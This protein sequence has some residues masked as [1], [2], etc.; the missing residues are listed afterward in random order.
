MYRTKYAKVEE[1]Y[2]ANINGKIEAVKTKRHIYQGNR[3]SISK[4]PSV[5][6]YPKINQ[7]VKGTGVRLQ[8]D[9]DQ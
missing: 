3:N 2:Y 6:T 8:R 9:H 1:G 5:N 4:K 7:V